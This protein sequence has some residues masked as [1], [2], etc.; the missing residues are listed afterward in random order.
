MRNRKVGFLAM[1]EASEVTYHCVSRVVG[2]EFLF[3]DK[4]K[5]VFV[6]MMRQLEGF[7]GVE[8]LSYCVMSNHFHVMV[9]VPQISEEEMTD[10]EFERRLR[11]IYKELEV[12]EV[13]VHLRKC[14]KNKAPK[15][16]RELKERYTYRMGNVSEYMKALKQRFSRWYNKSNARVGTLWEQRYGVTL[17]GPGWSTKVVA[18]YI[19]LNPL[20]AGIVD[21]P[22]NYRFSSYGEAVAKGNSIARERLFAVMNSTEPGASLGSGARGRAVDEKDALAKYRMLLAEEGEAQDQDAPMVLG[23]SKA[24]RTKKAKG[25]SKA[26]VKKVLE[27]NG[28]LSLA[29]LLRC[30]AR[31]FTSGF[32]I[33]SQ[34]YV[35]DML[36]TMKT[37]AGVFETRK[38]G[39]TR[40][41]HAKELKLATLRNLVRSPVNVG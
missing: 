15:M 13:M 7:C 4:E 17:V 3:G 11:C 36:E 30:K 31:Y 23:Q 35:E 26:E 10:A 27:K 25:F 32:A 20:R 1:N 40:L 37:K 39:A 6:K 33:G 29:Q 34:L 38:S 41:K 19:D 8:V 2:R 24:A 28:E 21:D 14:R 12:K 16:A 9:K 22:A 18:A 5:A